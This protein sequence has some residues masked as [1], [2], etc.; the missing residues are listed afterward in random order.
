MRMVF[1]EHTNGPE[2]L[3][4][5]AE[6]HF[7]LDGPLASMKLCGFG[8]WQG[9]DGVLY[10]TFPSRAFGAGTERKF[11]DYFRSTDGTASPSRAFKEW[12][13]AQYDAQREALGMPER[14]K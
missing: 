8:L 4:A 13:L 2:R 9:A 3:V 10:L 12:A 7:D 6:L 11:F 1:V 14:S 5:D